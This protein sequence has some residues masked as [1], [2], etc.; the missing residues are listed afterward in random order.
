MV[1]VRLAVILICL[2]FTSSASPTRSF[3]LLCPCPRPISHPVIPVPGH[4]PCITH[5]K[6]VVMT[7]S[8]LRAAH[9]LYF[10][11][12][13]PLWKNAHY[14]VGSKHLCQTTAVVSQCLHEASPRLENVEISEVLGT[15]LMGNKSFPFFST[16]KVSI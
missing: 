9:W 16:D 10:L 6:V 8:L 7:R 1:R 4:F 3:W 13:D 5:S 2:A 12:L 11:A 15:E 14:S